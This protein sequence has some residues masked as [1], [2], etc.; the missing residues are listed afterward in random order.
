MKTYPYTAWIFGTKFCG[1]RQVTITEH[2]RF[3]DREIDAQGHAYDPS[4][5]FDTKRKAIAGAERYLDRKQAEVA[6]LQSGI[7]ERR[8]YLHQQR[9]VTK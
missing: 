8:H 1:V 2:S 9:S 5:L 4:E 6:K 7:D 3:G